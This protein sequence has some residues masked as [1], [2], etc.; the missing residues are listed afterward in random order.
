MKIHYLVAPKKILGKAGK[1]VGVECLRMKLGDPDESG[2]PRP[3]TVPDSE[4]ILEA[5]S[6]IPAIGQS[7]DLSFLPQAKN[8]TFLKKGSAVDPVTNATNAAGV[9]AGGDM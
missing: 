6:V 1:V 8:G 3:T 9:F 4:F 7:I 2:R 5:D